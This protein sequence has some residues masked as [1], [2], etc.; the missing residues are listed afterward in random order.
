MTDKNKSIFP[1]GKIKVTFFAGLA[2]QRSGQQ[3]SEF[4]NL[5]RNKNWGEITAEEKQLNDQIVKSKNKTNK[6]ILSAYVT[7]FNKI[8]WIVTRFEEN[9]IETTILLPREFDYLFGR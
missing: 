6:K 5:H 9:S 2:L 1:L 4:L 3:S 7:S 8:I